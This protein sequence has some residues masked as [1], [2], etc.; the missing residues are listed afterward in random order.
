MLNIMKSVIQISVNEAP[1]GEDVM[2]YW[3]TMEF[4]ESLFKKFGA[5]HC[6]SAFDIAK[7]NRTQDEF[8]KEFIA[9][10]N[11]TYHIPIKYKLKGSD[12]EKHD[13]VE[14]NRAG[15]ARY[16]LWNLNLLCQKKS[17]DIC[18]K[19]YVNIKDYTKSS[20]PERGMSK[21]FFCLANAIARKENDKW[22]LH[23]AV[24]PANAVSAKKRR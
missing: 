9:R 17:T 20:N 12:H 7:V 19:L 11:K 3:T 8:V 24:Q 10:G 22:T 1:E 13:R 2:F 18:E 15:W 6:S 21:A 14:L 23:H 16:L 4:A 5:I